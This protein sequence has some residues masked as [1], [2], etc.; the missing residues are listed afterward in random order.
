MHVL[1]LKRK[2]KSGKFWRKEIFGFERGHVRKLIITVEHMFEFRN[3]PL[4]S[5][6]PVTAGWWASWWRW[7]RWLLISSVK[8]SRVYQVEVYLFWVNSFIYI[9]IYFVFRST[10]HFFSLDNRWICRVK[11]IKWTNFCF[12][13]ISKFLLTK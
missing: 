10:S 8:Y 12:N 6:F 2:Q 4:Q 9:Y 3:P 1:T 7:P 11:N 13:F 5:W